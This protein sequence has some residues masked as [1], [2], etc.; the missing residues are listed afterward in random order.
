[1]EM[2]SYS[3]IKDFIEITSNSGCKLMT[4][5]YEYIN[6]HQNIKFICKCGNEFETSYKIF[7]RKKSPKQ[8]CNECGLKNRIK[9]RT[10]P[11]ERLQDEIN[12]KFNNE[13][14]VLGEFKNRKTHTKFKHKI[15]GYE[16]LTTPDNFLRDSGCPN[17]NKTRKNITTES[18][19]KEV[20]DLTNGEYELV[21][22]YYNATKKTTFKHKVCNRI[23]EVTPHQF[24]SSGSRC[25]LCW[26][27][28][29][30]GK[31][32]KDTTQF[33]Q[34]VIEKYEDEYTIV[35][36]YMGARIRTE[37][38]HNKCDNIFKISPDNLLRG[39]GCP[40]CFESK[41][42]KRIA[43]YLKKNDI[44]YVPQFKIAECRNIKPLPFDFAIF[45]DNKLVCLIEYDGKQH[46]EV[47]PGWGGKE[48]FNELIKR[49]NTK[50]QYCKENKIKLIR[51]PYWQEK[52][53]ESILQ[54]ELVKS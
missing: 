47:I 44:E 41:G 18:F 14:E 25:P 36:E 27:E 12:E 26:N 10:L 30:L 32:Q 40:H 20:S 42:E 46:F 33:I 29:K 49:D 7:S 38:R 16:W 43:K 22:K 35:G 5:Q 31:L 3:E 13:F 50:N 8:Q 15:C 51:I 4:S 54:K 11:L 17:C 19:K 23:Y 6:T 45:N 24:I 53:I 28:S 1:M 2:L 39:K 37:V 52:D 21:G 34:E 48:M 9:K